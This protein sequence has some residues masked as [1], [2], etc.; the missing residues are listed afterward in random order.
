MNELFE[1]VTN[2]ER[3]KIINSIDNFTYKFDKEEV[4]TKDI[5]F[6]KSIC[7]VLKGKISIYKF[8][9]SC[10]TKTEKKIT[11]NYYVQIN[12]K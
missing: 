12:S 3:N 4:I 8:K 6:K 1:N 11:M 5:F 9:R 10:C 7:L 2:I